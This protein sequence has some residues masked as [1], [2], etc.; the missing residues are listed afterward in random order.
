MVWSRRHSAF[1]LC[2]Y[3]IW[4]IAS[5]CLLPFIFTKK[6]REIV[7]EMSWR[8]WLTIIILGITNYTLTQGA[9]FLALKYLPAST[10]TLLL[11]FTTVLVALF[12]LLFLSESLS[13][14]KWAKAL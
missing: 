11:N 9:Q 13:L 8:E 3:A 12:S 14:K 7:K 1:N 10:V 6:N 2:R 4:G 5:L